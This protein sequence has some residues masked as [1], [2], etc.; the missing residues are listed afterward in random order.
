M[1]HKRTEDPTHISYKHYGGRGIKVCEEWHKDR[2]IEGFEAFLKFVGPRPTPHHTIDRI[3]NDLGY[4]PYQP[5][6]ERQVRWA[7]ASQQRQNQRPTQGRERGRGLN[8]H[9]QNP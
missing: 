9:A 7:T 3:N 1:M 4:Q 5:N 6:G 2:G 8:G